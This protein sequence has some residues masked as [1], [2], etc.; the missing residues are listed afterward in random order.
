M[1]SSPWLIIWFVQQVLGCVASLRNWRIS[2]KTM[3]R[4]EMLVYWIRSK[5][6]SDATSHER[7]SK[8]SIF[9][10]TDVKPQLTAGVRR[11]NRHSYKCCK[12]LAGPCRTPC[13]STRRTAYIW[14]MSTQIWTR[15]METFSSFVSLTVVQWDHQYIAKVIA[16]LISYTL[17]ATNPG[18]TNLAAYQQ[19]TRGLAPKGFWLR[20]CW[21]TGLHFA[22]ERQT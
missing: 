7:F 14:I 3:F 9:V 8:L 5:L 6:S 2:G 10:A 19:L 4:A 20:R 15:R 21:P 17:P 1:P 16:T 11:Y 18:S 13:W 22:L 12:Y